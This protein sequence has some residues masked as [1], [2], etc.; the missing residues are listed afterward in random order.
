MSHHESYYERRPARVLGCLNH[1]EISVILSGNSSATGTRI[2]PI[3]WV[4]M[5]LRMPNSEFDLVM[6]F[7]EGKNVRVLRKDAPFLDIDHS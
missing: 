5:D 7:P 3:D 6:Q 1:G 2:L 4:P